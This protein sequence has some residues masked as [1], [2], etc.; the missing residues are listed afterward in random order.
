MWGIYEAIRA[1]LPED[2][3][4]LMRAHVVSFRDKVL[5]VM[6]MDSTTNTREADKSA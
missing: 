4:R 6:A 5:D 3:G 2:S 1:Q